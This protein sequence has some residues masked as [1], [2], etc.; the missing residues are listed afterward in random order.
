VP[1]AAFPAAAVAAR[2]A[3]RHTRDVRGFVLA[4][5]LLSA[6]LLVSIDQG[7]TR[8]NRAFRR[9]EGAA[10]GI[11]NPADGPREMTLWQ[12]LHRD[13]T[14]SRWPGSHHHE[15]VRESINR[16]GLSLSAVAYVVLGV[17]VVGMT[18]RASACVV[19][20]FYATHFALLYIAFFVSARYP[21]TLAA[22][23]SVPTII[24]VGGAAVA[25]RAAERSGVRER[26]CS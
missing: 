4:A 13:A 25:A 24:L 1:L 8:T 26:T 11:A 3:A 16:I 10:Q 19:G 12:L 15:F 23:T 5:T 9:I 20:A 2:L 14:I 7:A 22:V 18:G 21:A 6:L 17:A